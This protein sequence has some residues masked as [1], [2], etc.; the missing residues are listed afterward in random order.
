MKEKVL[1]VLESI[2]PG[3]QADGGDVEFVKIDEDNVVY[4]RLVGACGGCPMSQI[5]LKQGIERIMKMQIPEVK[6]V[7]AI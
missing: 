3:L 2:R 4:I 1:K 5:T 7:E 6:A